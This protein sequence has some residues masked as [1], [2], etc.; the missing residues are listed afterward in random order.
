MFERLLR[1]NVMTRRLTPVWINVAALTVMAVSSPSSL[2]AQAPGASPAQPATAQ[3]VSAA[4]TVNKDPRLAI[5]GTWILNEQFSTRAPEVAVGPN[6][7]QANPGV[8]VGDRGYRGR[9]QE[10]A[11]SRIALRELTQPAAQLVVT[12]D[13]TNVSVTGDSG[14]AED[15]L[16]DDKPGTV[17]LDGARTVVR[18]LWQKNILVQ[19]YKI[20]TTKVTRMVQ[21]SDEGIQLIVTVR[22]EANERDTGVASSI[23]PMQFV[24]DRK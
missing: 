9:N 2:M 16:A 24:Y 1:E 20:G 11:G 4:G 5:A 21:T 17:L 22:V 7:G 8:L 12:S 6:S 3:A 15:Y 13:G 14:K 23:A 19:E 18:S 10:T